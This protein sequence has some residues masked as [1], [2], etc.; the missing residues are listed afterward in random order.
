MKLRE[1]IQE[2]DDNSNDGGD[3][4]RSTVLN[5]RVSLARTGEERIGLFVGSVVLVVRVLLSYEVI[6]C[7]CSGK[8]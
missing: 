3:V 2:R 6:R 4:L 5:E 7:E 8:G 1:R